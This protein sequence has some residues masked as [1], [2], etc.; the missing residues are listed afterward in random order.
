MANLRLLYKN[1][2]EQ[3]STQ[4]RWL[5]GPSV[6]Y[7]NSLGCTNGSASLTRKSGA[8]DFTT[9]G[10]KFWSLLAGTIAAR[11]PGGTRVTNVTPGTLTMSANATSTISNNPG[12]AGSFNPTHGLIETT[13]GPMSNVLDG[14]LH[15]V[16]DPGVD[17]GGFGYPLQI[18]FEFDLVGSTAV[19][20][21]GVI[22]P[23]THNRSNGGIDQIDV[24]SGSTY[25]SWT[26]R[27]SFAPPDAIRDNSYATVL[28]SVSARFWRIGISF[29]QRADLSGLWL[30]IVDQDLGGAPVTMDVRRI[31]PASVIRNPAGRAFITRQGPDRRVWRFPWSA[32]TSSRR[33]Q[34]EAAFENQG[35]AGSFLYRPPMMLDDVDAFYPVEF[36]EQQMGWT[37][38][39][40]TTERQDLELEELT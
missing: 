20:V 19:T 24:D 15:T 11:F 28:G 26:P 18:F 23:R 32:L 33:A 17:A 40:G 34:I 29:A 22:A 37:K 5:N 2:L 8:T 6:A 21:Y 4:T 1:H 10:V 31:R 3:T 39:F 36:G 14:N 13:D 16:W 35:V 9:A 25:G 7:A 27:A 30:G 12:E 38:V